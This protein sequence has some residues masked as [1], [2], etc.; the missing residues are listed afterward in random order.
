MRARD[1]YRVSNPLFF[2]VTNGAVVPKGLKIAETN[3]IRVIDY[4]RISKVGQI[5]RDAVL[6][7]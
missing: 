5:V 1:R 3:N 4:S 7:A 2:L 6:N